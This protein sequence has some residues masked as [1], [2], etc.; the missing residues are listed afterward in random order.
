M[1]ASIIFKRTPPTGWHYVRELPVSWFVAGCL[2]AGIV[3]LIGC[4]YS[5]EFRSKWL[6]RIAVGAGVVAALLYLGIGLDSLRCYMLQA[7][8]ANIL[9]VAAQSF[10]GAMYQ[11]PGSPDGSYSLMYGPVTFLVYRT[12]LMAGGWNH[13]WIL[14]GAIVLADLGFLTALYF[15]LRKFVSPLVSIAL[16]A[17]PLSILMQH[18]ES[19]LGLRADIWTA[20]AAALA[21]LCGFLEPEVAAVLL[22]GLLGGILVGFKISGGP[23]ILFPLLVL[24]RRFGLRA[25]VVAAAIATAAAFAP[26]ALGNVSLHNYIAWISFMRSEGISTAMLWP[27]LALAVFL[28][29]P[30][31][32]M[33]LCMRPP[34][35]DFRQRLPEL[36]VIVL[37]LLMAVTTS[38]PGSGPWY[39]WHI[40][41]SIVV[42]LGLAS[43]SLAAISPEE[44]ALPV[45]FIAVACLVL[46]CANFPR[47]CEIIRLSAMPRRVGLARQSMDRYLDLYRDRSSLQMGY[48]SVPDDVSTSLRY[49]LVYMGQPYTLEGNTGK[50][51]TILLPFPVHVQQQMDTCKDDVWLI[52][53]GEAPFGNYMF[54]ASLHQAFVRDYRID[55]S[56]AVYDA[57]ACRHAGGH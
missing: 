54:P 48:G 27:N 1:L 12:V 29:S 7:D 19:A 3:L 6:R 34:A 25:P 45:Y 11:M 47:A 2:L 37:C 56:D 35:V 52:P 16:L 15:L 5:P 21:L 26:F 49:V 20:L 51:E 43:K 33:E 44:Q 4:R 14:R 38:K 57:W 24:Y 55:R 39:F 31:L 53:H 28:I 23:A 32:V 36:A 9:G 40:V 41:P 42:Y 17:F 46:T 30:C 8:E 50:F 22:T 18:P 13:F 10:H